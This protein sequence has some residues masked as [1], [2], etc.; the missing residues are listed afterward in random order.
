MEGSITC[1]NFYHFFHFQKT[2]ARRS[3]QG[4]YDRSA[5]G[6]ASVGAPGG[7]T[8]GDD[9]NITEQLQELRLDQRDEHVG[10]RAPNVDVLN[11]VQCR[12]RYLEFIRNAA[13][14]AKENPGM[15]TLNIASAPQLHA[16]PFEE[17]LKAIGDPDIYRCVCFFLRES[18]FNSALQASALIRNYF[19]E[20]IARQKIGV[21]LST[22]KYFHTKV[23]CLHHETQRY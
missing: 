17:V 10:D 1:F 11:S 7:A 21:F 15:V 5:R 16:D 18:A 13:T 12:N 19:S 8:G 23:G 14:K 20:H 22:A 6:G 4:G 2:R 3:Q 9:E